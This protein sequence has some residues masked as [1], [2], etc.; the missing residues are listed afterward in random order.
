MTELRITQINLHHCKAASYNL[1]RELC[2]DKAFVALVQEPWTLGNSI[3][4]RITGA[5][6][7]KYVGMERPRACIYI[8]KNVAGWM[9]PN[10]S[11]KDTVTV[12]VTANNK[13]Y[14]FVSSYMADNV[15]APPPMVKRV[16]EH[17]E[18]HHIPLIIGC[19][20]N[21]HH[22]L[23]GS[24]NTNSRGDSLLEYLAGTTMEWCNIGSAP[25]F[26]VANRREVL[27][28]TLA[29][30][31]AIADIQN[32]HVSD[33]PSLSD[34]AYLKYTIKCQ[35][36]PILL[37]RFV[38]STD[39]SKYEEYLQKSV[40]KN[41]VVREASLKSVREIDVFAE[42]LT[43]LMTKAFKVACPVKAVKQ[44]VP[45]P[46]WN[47]ELSSLRKAARNKLRKAKKTNSE[48]SWKD[49]NES[50]KLFKGEIRKAKKLSW[51]TYCQSMESITETAKISQLLKVDDKT[52][53]NTVQKPSGVYTDSPE[54]TLKVMLDALL[55]RNGNC[56]PEQE[57]Q[58]RHIMT[59]LSHSIFTKSAI[60]MALK[61]FH[62]FKSPG[63][64][65]IY[66]AQLQHGCAALG[67]AFLKLF[68]TCF[69]FGYIPR[70]WQKSKGVFI[71]KPGK[72][73]YLHVKS[74][75]LITLSSFQLKLMERL[76]LWHINA[77]PRVQ[78]TLSDNL[79]GYRPGRSTESA[80][81]R[82]V[83][84]A[85]K[86]IVNGHYGLGIFLD[87]EGAFDNITFASLEGALRTAGV[88][89]VVIRWISHALNHREI[90]VTLQNAEVIR[91]VERGSS[92]GGI[93]SAFLW[94]LVVNQLLK[95]YNNMPSV[96]VQAYADDIVIYVSGIDL[97]VLRDLA[98]QAINIAENWARNNGLSFS[99][100]KTE[101]V[102][103]TWNR[104]QTL[105]NPLRLGHLPIKTVNQARYLG[106]IL[107][108]KLSW[109]PHIEDRTKKATAALMQ[110]RRAFSKTWGLRPKYRMWLYTAIARPIMCYA[111]GI[112]INAAK[113]ATLANKL[114]KVQR[115]GCMMVTSAFPGTPTAAL[116]VMLNLPPLEIYLEGE[117]Y[118]ACYRL[119]KGNTWTRKTIG[120][121][122]KLQSHVDISNKGKSK[123]QSLQ[124]DKDAIIPKLHLRKTFCIDV[125]ER[126]DIAALLEEIERDD[127]I[128]CYTDGS[129]KNEKTGSGV[130]VSDT[131]QSIQIRLSKS[132]S[133]HATVFQSEITAITLAVNELLEREIARRTIHILSDSRSA[134]Q[135]L[136]KAVV[137]STCVE[138]CLGKLDALSESNNTVILHWVPGHT[139]IPGNEEADR[140]A[141]LGA[142]NPE[143]EISIPA[144]Y[145]ICKA[146]IESWMAKRHKKYWAL[147]ETC[148]QSKETLP[149]PEKY[150]KN[151]ILNLSSGD[152]RDLVQ[153]L[154]GHGN[155]AKHRHL[156]SKNT[157]PICAA[158]GLE[159][160][161]PRHYVE[162]CPVYTKHRLECFE[163]PFVQMQCL[164]EEK[165]LYQLVQFN[166]CT[167][168]LHN[169]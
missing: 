145:G 163:G 24:T 123:I 141:R 4:G 5:F 129:R 42:K 44:A 134:I 51:R 164:V 64:D 130:Y 169:F 21:A 70:I 65:G 68:K 115:L 15:D 34:H 72:D 136:H 9:L 138:R 153:V 93:L 84:K 101:A 17:C 148:R 107:D 97:T 7:Y 58:Y 132:L 86:T 108:S 152:L 26:I 78:R 45:T 88:E 56:Q 157:S 133:N 144:S 122:G 79:H 117:A 20:A 91:Q 162:R 57:G 37:K 94:N 140:L 85:E 59:D 28:L 137:T 54:E 81:H 48:Q 67:E 31:D 19:D 109:K 40:E 168:R 166:R 102:V 6:L 126:E 125:R 147:T 111:A 73:N 119:E 100:S 99:A 16:I 77:T 98:Q 63:E 135:A 92:Q 74:F 116:E 32:W 35:K 160:E 82:L 105:S 150:V 14:M 114:Q 49:Y 167:K 33:L 25:T 113:K 1:T 11:D 158:C 36:L 131:L 12:K 112:W 149:K 156:C 142:E 47:N 120:S 30:P 38:K 103:F 143:V 155:L 23:W 106:V 50:Q 154:T 61:Q 53:L 8:S 60:E 80:L 90:K 62:P 52:K 46:W 124:T 18:I 110:C 66:P 10:L 22:E 96:F 151:F 127:S 89:D 39:W 69:G 128:H 2:K 43:D 159:E 83:S 76:V 139:D 13:T 118:K 104:K 146:D 3:K 55:P 161:T 87:I 71:P 29:S 95:L 75:R 121:K 41:S 165:K 27:D